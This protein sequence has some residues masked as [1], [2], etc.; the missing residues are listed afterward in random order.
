[1]SDLLVIVPSR[2]RPDNIKRLAQAWK[3]TEASADLLIV[4]DDDDETASD[5][6]AECW[7]TVGERLKLAGSL[8]K[9]A[10][11]YAEDYKYIGFMGDD[12]V[13]RTS[14]WDISI[15]SALE[16]SRLVYGNDL[17]QGANL[18]TAV[19]M[20]AAIV[21]KL[22]YMVP[23]GMIHLYLDNF[24]KTL[25]EHLESIT[26]LPDVV[27]EHLHPSCGK[28]SNDTQYDEVNAP[29]LYDHDGRVFAEYVNSQLALDVAKLR[30]E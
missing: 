30:G 29:S 6:P 15:V 17:L 27:I 13:P 10:V 1:M 18:P 8:N 26:Y 16:N 5:Y 21:S 2:S 3:D 9:A 11:E 28:A 20:D 14:K 7:T 25:G 4:L 22:G 24:W 23:P 19:F 12:H